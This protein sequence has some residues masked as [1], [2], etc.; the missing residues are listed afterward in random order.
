MCQL[1]TRAGMPSTLHMVK[2]TTCDLCS[3]KPIF[4]ATPLCCPN[5]HQQSIYKSIGL[6]SLRRF[7]ET[8]TN[9]SALW[10][11]HSA[12]YIF[13]RWRHNLHSDRARLWL[14]RNSGLLFV[15]FV[16]WQ[17]LT[18]NIKMQG[19]VATRFPIESSMLLLWN[20]CRHV[21]ILRRF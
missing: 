3:Y 18:I 17:H 13:D 2:D 8:L 10:H 11:C 6:G 16:R 15:N 1:R 9:I 5:Y 7:N 4:P 12:S 19:F 20:V 14:E 21:G